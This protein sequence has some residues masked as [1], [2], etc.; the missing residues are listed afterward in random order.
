MRL[1]HQHCS[2]AITSDGERKAASLLHVGGTVEGGKLLFV[3]DRLIAL[4]LKANLQR[5]AVSSEL[6]VADI[7]DL[8]SLWL[9]QRLQ[10]R[11]VLNWRCHNRLQSCADIVSLDNRFVSG[12]GLASDANE[13]WNCGIAQ[14]A[15]YLSAPEGTEERPYYLDMTPE[16]REA[17]NIRFE[18]AME[19]EDY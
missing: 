10:G 3:T 13:A 16:E 19:M 2:A 6:M 12:G 17:D 4:V 14:N 5:L 7:A 11:S 8:V 15:G 1:Q 18:M 9:Q